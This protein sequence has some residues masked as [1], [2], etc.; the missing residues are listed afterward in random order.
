MRRMPSSPSV[1][2]SVVASGGTAS[3][4]RP[5]ARIRRSTLRR[6]RG[7]RSEHRP[8]AGYGRTRAR[9]SGRAGRT[10]LPSRRRTD[11]R[12][13]QPRQRRARPRRRARRPSRRARSAGNPQGL[14][15]AS[16]AS[17]RCFSSCGNSP[18]IITWCWRMRKNCRGARARSGTLP[19]SSRRS[20]TPRASR[21]RSR[22]RP[23]RAALPRGRRRRSDRRCATRWC[24]TLSKTIFSDSGFPV[25][26]VGHA[27]LQR[28]HSVQVNASRPSFQVR[29]RASR[30]PARICDSS[31][32]SISLS[33]STGGTRLAGP[34]A[35]E[36]ERRQRGDDVEVLAE[37]QDDEERQHD[38]HLGP[39]EEPV[40]DL[41]RGLRQRA[42]RAGDRT[43]GERPASARARSAGSARRGARSGSRRRRSRSP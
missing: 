35:P 18:S 30:T 40:A 36:V 13:P 38:H 2:A 23:A 28:P 4:C 14:P 42:H 21:R 1:A 5:G 39:V 31:S 16:Y 17:N 19:R 27:S 24:L 11:S 26:W 34:A 10:T 22:G 37:R 33:R 12:A 8:A 15:S 32:A 20:C 41:E 43:A 3:R 29:S 9:S 6:R 25:R 7:W